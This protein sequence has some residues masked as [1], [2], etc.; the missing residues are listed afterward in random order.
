MLTSV[1]LATLILGC[2]NC[3]VVVVEIAIDID[4]SIGYSLADLFPRFVHVL[5]H[6]A[7]LPGWQLVIV[8]YAVDIH[9]RHE[10]ERQL[11]QQIL[12]LVVLVDVCQYSGD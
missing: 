5:P 12:Q 11:G 8:Y 1:L 3:S 9:E 7:S 10:D 6:I 2:G 4:A